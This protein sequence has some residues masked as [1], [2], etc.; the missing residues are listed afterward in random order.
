MSIR[1]I[2]EINHDLLAALDNPEALKKMVL[3][4]AMGAH[5]PELNNGETPEIAPGVRVLM[6]R[7]HS[8]NVTIQSDW[9]KVEL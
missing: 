8:S 7:H 3:N 6:Q 5:M 1:T 4:L 2:I 9:A